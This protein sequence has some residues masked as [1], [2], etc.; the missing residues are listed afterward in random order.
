MNSLDLLILCSCMLA[1]SSRKTQEIVG[2]VGIVSWVAL[3]FVTG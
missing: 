1:S 2:V 3:V